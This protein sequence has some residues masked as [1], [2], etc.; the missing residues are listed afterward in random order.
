M[1]SG[2]EEDD[3]HSLDDGEDGGPQQ[4]DADQGVLGWLRHCQSD[5]R[6]QIE[7][8]LRKTDVKS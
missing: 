3:E 5:D 4:E 8:S 7:P 2:E 6:A 1:S